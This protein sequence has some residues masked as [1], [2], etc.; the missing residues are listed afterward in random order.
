MELGFGGEGRSGTGV[1]PRL[2]GV[3]REYVILHQVEP[4]AYFFDGLETGF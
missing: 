1:T 3:G 4:A 2:A